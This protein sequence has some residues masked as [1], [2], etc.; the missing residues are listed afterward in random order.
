LRLCNRRRR[1]RRF[2]GRCWAFYRL[3]SLYGL[4]RAFW[5][6]FRLWGGFRRRFRGWLWFWSWLRGWF[7][8]SH[9]SHW[10]RFSNHFLSASDFFCP[11]NIICP[12]CCIRSLI[13]R[14][15]FRIR[16]RTRSGA[17]TVTRMVKQSI[18]QLPAVIRNNANKAGE[19]TSKPTFAIV[20]CNVAFV[21]K[22]VI[23]IIPS[24]LKCLLS[25]NRVLAGYRGPS[26]S[27]IGGARLPDHEEKKKAHK[28]YS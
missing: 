28:D 21:Q 26:F 7:Y 15:I 11:S 16:S 1:L 13:H 23:F 3:R 24:N 6:R 18:I 27:T 5:S 2:R 17:R 9:R 20:L 19:A 10:L 4:Y 25:A 12:Y 14:I 22:V 8:G